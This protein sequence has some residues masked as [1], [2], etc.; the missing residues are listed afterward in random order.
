MCLGW[1]LTPWLS[2]NSPNL[3][4]K[5]CLPPWRLLR[6]TP[7]PWTCQELWWQGHG[8]DV[9]PSGLCGHVGSMPAPGSNLS[10]TMRSFP[11]TTRPLLS[12]LPLQRLPSPSSPLDTHSILQVPPSQLWGIEG[13]PIAATWGMGAP[14][15]RQR[16]GASQGEHRQGSSVSV[17]PGSTLGTFDCPSPSGSAVPFSAAA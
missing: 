14:G 4:A 6:T 11:P 15:P 7:S 5:I 1:T 9:G 8:M 3:P 2:L 10:L 12:V 17:S 16:A 13:S